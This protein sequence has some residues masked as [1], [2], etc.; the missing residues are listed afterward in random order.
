MGRK[1]TT[2]GSEV[3]GL[4]WA[5]RIASLTES[6]WVDTHVESVARADGGPATILK[7]KVLPVARS[8]AV[9]GEVA[10]GL[11]AQVVPVGASERGGAV[12]VLL[13]G[14]LLP[15]ANRT[16]VPREASV[17]LCS[18]GVAVGVDDSDHV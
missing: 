13:H 3:E 12:G 8:G 6:L 2:L 10:S 1:S 11:R 5:W 17:R 14:P 15:V 18:H 4:P 9:G 16:S 7:T